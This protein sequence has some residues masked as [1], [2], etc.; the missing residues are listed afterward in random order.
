MTKYTINDFNKQ[1]S[2][3]GTCLD[4]LW[5]RRFPNGANC[6]VCQTVRKFHRVK[7]RKVYECDHCGYQISPTAGTI[8]HKSPT[9]LRYWFYAVYL[10][11]STK[12]GISAKQLQRE[13]GVTY[14]TAWRMFKQIR[15]LM[16]EGMSPFKG[17]IE[18]DETYIGGK[19]PGKCGRGAGHKTIVLGNR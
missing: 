12:C 2:D 18:V 19:C 1:F 4:W 6:P 13:L 11:A 9:P 17:Q 16:D 8:L 15:N 14:K 7:S 10:M 5:Q 3:E